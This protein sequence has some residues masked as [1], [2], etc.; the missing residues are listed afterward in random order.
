LSLPITH[1]LL[2]RERFFELLR[3][4]G[5]VGLRGANE[6]A[7]QGMARERLRLQ[8]R[9]ELTSEKPGMTLVQLDDL[10]ELPIGRH[11]G[12]GQPG[13][14]QHRKVFL[15]DLVAVP[16]A[17]RDGGFS[18]SALSDR[19]GSQIAGILS[20][21]HRPAESLDS[22]QVPELEDDLVARLLVELRRV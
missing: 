18:I 15:V 3:A 13:L 11:A 6:V 9:V 17:L 22:D 14:L 2:R 19:A 12:K 21:A 20:E 4:R 5:P 16:V 10:D 1:V 8:L 7:E